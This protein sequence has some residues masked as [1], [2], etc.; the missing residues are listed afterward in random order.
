VLGGFALSTALGGFALST[1]ARGLHPLTVLGGFALS[2][3]LGGFT[4]ST[5]ARGLHPPTALGGFALST[6]LG[7]FALSTYARGLCPSTHITRTKHPDEFQKIHTYTIYIYT[8]FRNS[9]RSMRYNALICPLTITF[10]DDLSSDTISCVSAS[11]IM[12]LH[13]NTT[14]GGWRERLQQL[15]VNLGIMSTHEG[16]GD[17]G[18]AVQVLLNKIVDGIAI[19]ESIKQHRQAVGFFIQRKHGLVHQSKG[20]VARFGQHSSL[21]D[22][23]L[24]K[25]QLQRLRPICPEIVSDRISV[26]LSSTKVHVHASGF[27]FTVKAHICKEEKNVRLYRLK[28]RSRPEVPK[29]LH[30]RDFPRF[31]TSSRRNF[32]ASTARAALDRATST[33]AVTTFS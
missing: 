23:V 14:T 2:T 33:L 26:R 21:G 27:S 28:S 16:K 11:S 19:L 5:Y 29:D 3:V 8:R 9:A 7:G 25:C 12:M 1:Y 13:L 6:E 18:S 31:S 22:P 17:H 10:G 15:Q 4:L 32:S 30:F 20:T 24:E